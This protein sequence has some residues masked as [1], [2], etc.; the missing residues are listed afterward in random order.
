M[1]EFASDELSAKQQYNILVGTVIPRPIAWI[2]SQSEEGVVNL[3]PFS[4]YNIVSYDPAIL[5]VSIQRNSD[6]SMK[7][8]TR[9]ILATNE[10]VIH[11]VS[12]DNLE[13]ANQTAQALPYNVSEFDESKMTL[14]ESTSL[15][16]PGLLQSKSRFETSFYEHIEIKDDDGVT[17][18]DLILLKVEHFHLDESLFHENHI[19]AEILKPMSRLA[20]NDYSKLGQTINLER[21]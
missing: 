13:L 20:G 10:A 14:V 15:S 5:S 18:A 11:S 17:K 21:P 7:D 8:T 2:S 4:F 19:D 12:E 6:G 1:F 16:V 9:N 3:A